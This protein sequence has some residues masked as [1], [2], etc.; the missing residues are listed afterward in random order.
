MSSRRKKLEQKVGA[1]AFAIAE[2]MFARKNAEQAERLGA[3]LGILAWRLDK[4]HRERTISNLALAFPELSDSKRV[5]MAKEVFRHFG[6]T[7]ADFM[8]AEVRTAKEVLDSM[9]VEN[10]ENFKA[11]VCGEHGVL[12][13]TGHFGNWERFGH[14]M[15]LQGHP[16]TVVA[17]DA[18]DSGIN[19]AM[20]RKREAQGVK[21]LSRGNTIRQIFSCLKANQAVAILPD[22]NS[23][24]AFV[25]FFGKPCGT[26]LG[27]AVL[28]LRTGA[29]LIPCY[30]ARTGPGK[31]LAIIRPALELPEEQRT[32]EGIMFA[33][34][35]ELEAV[36]R[37]YPTQWLW[38]HD[39]WKSARRAG[40]L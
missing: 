23:N 14:W 31:Y 3:K 36:I 16:L 22:Q 21:V 34:H 2:R 33:L 20:A 1:R 15:T 37:E 13:I 17:R 28:H 25:P 8:R 32:P 39:R 6:R 10:Q 40:M 24:E 38:M 4:K 27:P 5:E 35:A 11:A 29:P 19:L 7:A 18:N 12:A 30:C 9:E 26:V